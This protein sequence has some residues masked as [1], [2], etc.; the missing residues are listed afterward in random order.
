MEEQQKHDRDVGNYEAD[1][2]SN[3]VMTGETSTKIKRCRG[4]TKMNHVFTRRL[5]ERPV[6]TLN[7]ELQPVLKTNKVITEFSSF[8]GT[9]ARLYI[10][11]DFVSW[12]KVPEEEKNGWW[13]YVKTKYIIPEEGKDWVMKSLDDNRSV[14]KSRI[15][16]R[17]Y[18]KY[19][20]DEDR[21]R[22]KPATIPL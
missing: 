15:K 7:Y 22:N 18:S 21:I 17:H 8:L 13:E 12:S 6:V 3:H 1:H 19:D 11:L 5:D 14:Y 10:P 4:P 9:V 16:S 20:N 2:D